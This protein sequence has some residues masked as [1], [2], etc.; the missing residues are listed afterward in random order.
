MKQLPTDVHWDIDPSVEEGSPLYGLGKKAMFTALGRQEAGGIDFVSTTIPFG[1]EGTATA[2]ISRGIKTITLAYNPPKKVVELPKQDESPLVIPKGKGAWSM[3][4]GTIYTSNSSTFLFY[5]SA[6]CATVNELKQVWQTAPRLNGHSSVFRTRKPGMYTGIMPRVVQA[7]YGVG[8]VSDGSRAYITPLATKKSHRTMTYDPTWNKTHGV[9]RAGYQNHWL[10]EISRTNG[11]LAMPLPL[12]E[13]TTTPAY[14][15]RVKSRKDTD[16]QLVLDEFGGIPT[17][18]NFPSGDVLESAIARGY[19]LRLKT[20]AQMAAFYDKGVAWNTFSGWSFNSNGTAA[21]NTC[22]CHWSGSARL[23]SGSTNSNSMSYIRS[24]HWGLFLSLSQHDVNNLRGENPTPVGTGSA[25]LT[26]QSSG[27]VYENTIRIPGGGTGFEDHVVPSVPFDWSR[28]PGTYIDSGRLGDTRFGAVVYVFFDGNNLVRIKQSP[29]MDYVVSSRDDWLNPHTG[30]A[31]YD[32]IVTKTS[33]YFQPAACYPENWDR[34]KRNTTRGW[35]PV[36][37]RTD[38]GLDN[39]GPDGAVAY[40]VITEF[41]NQHSGAVYSTRNAAVS[42]RA[43]TD[44]TDRNGEGQ[45]GVHWYRPW[46]EIDRVTFTSEETVAR[47]PGGQW[48]SLDGHQFGSYISGQNSQN[49]GKSAYDYRISW[50]FDANY[51]AGYYHA[52]MRDAKAA[53]CGS[54]FSVTVDYY[55]SLSYINRSND[56]RSFVSYNV[57]QGKPLSRPMDLNWVGSV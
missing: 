24:E 28:N 43:H 48:A 30:V 5:P 52:Y 14:R 46:K 12:F 44:Y 32:G 25:T 17:G 40:T 29:F 42:F 19:V 54:R 49:I 55:G 37:T 4:H 20:A 39:H 9:Y 41:F 6:T 34:R 15:S 45:F 13:S 51:S 23:S 10:I 2:T 38:T 27:Y 21:H 57:P 47:L 53:R 56:M 8:A 16:T 22:W 3:L 31:Y 1:L 7:I 26:L 35:A 11:I 33:A 50:V 36:W 18:E